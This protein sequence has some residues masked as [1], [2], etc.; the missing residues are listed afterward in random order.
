MNIDGAWITHYFGADNLVLVSASQANVHMMLI[1]LT[2]R[3]REWGLDWKMGSLQSAPLRFAFK[4]VQMVL[5][6]GQKGPLGARG[7]K[8]LRYG[9]FDSSFQM[10]PDGRRFSDLWGPAGRISTCFMY[11]IPPWLHFDVL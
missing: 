3:I 9:R 5:T 7:R 6:G 2:R 8:S 11:K 4:Q 1:Q 10:V